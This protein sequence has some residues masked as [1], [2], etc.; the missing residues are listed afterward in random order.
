M[1][2]PVKHHDINFQVGGHIYRDRSCEHARWER[3]EGEPHP[4]VGT[5]IMLAGFALIALLGVMAS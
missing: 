5:L 1:E 3:P 4:L 2:H